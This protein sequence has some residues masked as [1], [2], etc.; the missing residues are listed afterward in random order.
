LD[1]F[2]VNRK[3]GR[4]EISEKF[5]LRVP[6]MFDYLMLITMFSVVS[7]GINEVRR[8]SKDSTVT[9]PWSK[10]FAELQREVDRGRFSKAQCGCGWPHHLLIP[11]GTAGGM[12]FDLFV[13]VTNGREDAIGDLGS[14]KDNYCAQP[15]DYCGKLGKYE[16]PDKK[17][18]SYPFDRRPPPGVT[19]LEELAALIPNSKTVQVCNK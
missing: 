13:M 5:N 19:D 15:F 3:N 14:Q 11:K 18:M 1:I 10:S 8:R 16:Y 6:N 9:K 2:T 17:P 12:T 4:T 7:I